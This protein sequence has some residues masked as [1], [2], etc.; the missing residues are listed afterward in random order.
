M[1]DLH[2]VLN[3][4]G[5]DLVKSGKTVVQTRLITDFWSKK[6]V[7]KRYDKIVIM[8]GYAKPEEVDR[9]IV[10]PYNGY[11]IRNVTSAFT[12]NEPQDVYVIKANIADEIK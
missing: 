9:R 11:R 8:C 12:N 5:F 6:L 1:S 10:L 2:L 3:R 7:D 4:A